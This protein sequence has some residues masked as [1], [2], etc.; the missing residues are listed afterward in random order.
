MILNWLAY[1]A[2]MIIGV[3][4]TSAFTRRIFAVLLV[5]GLMVPIVS[6]FVM[7]FLRKKVYVSMSADSAEVR[8][9][10][11]IRVTLTLLNRSAFACRCAEI[12]I[13][14]ESVVFMKNQI[15]KVL[16]DIPAERTARRRIDV[17]VPHSGEFRIR[18]TKVRIRSLF[19]L[20]TTKGMIDR[21]EQSC[22][23]YPPVVTVGHEP[24]RNN[25]IAYIAKE[26][27]STTRPGDDPS[28]MFGAREYRPGDRQNRI[29]W[30][31]TAARDELFVKELGLPVDTSTLLLLD[32]FRMKSNELE[33]IYDSLLTTMSSLAWK[34]RE[35][36]HIFYIG[37]QP[38]PGKVWRVRVESD[39]E[40]QAAL[41]GVFK[42]VPYDEETS[43]V[44]TYASHFSDER[45]RNILYVTNVY[46]NS[47]EEGL[48]LISYDAKVSVYLVTNGGES[49][50]PMELGDRITRTVR[51]EHEEEDLG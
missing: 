12:T 18:L 41:L 6:L 47:S 16:T 11:E 2:L 39:E 43:V 35:S 5:F 15:I 14:R 40:L 4:A 21:S 26:E 44:K 22:M 45:Y 7:L 10:E 3:I 13:V 1:L 20:F 49:R 46:A 51:A 42:V 37:W 25:P 29:H 24:L 19:G 36:R 48:G 33:T 31:L 32:V 8:P 27:Y 34:I 50:T 23:V 38:E 30:K 17:Y 9:G 28:E